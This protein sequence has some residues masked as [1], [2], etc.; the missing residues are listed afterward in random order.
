MNL[1]R[2]NEYHLLPLPL[3]FE[4]KN[5]EYIP[6]PPPPPPPTLHAGSELEAKE[7]LADRVQMEHERRLVAAREQA[8][9]DV[10]ETFE[11]LQHQLEQQQQRIAEV[12]RAGLRVG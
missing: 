11:K 10:R 1:S 2:Q 7:R 12:G 9:R 4:K 5:L 3:T 8:E 6:L